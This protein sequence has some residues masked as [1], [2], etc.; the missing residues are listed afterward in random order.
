[1]SASSVDTVKAKSPRQTEVVKPVHNKAMTPAPSKAI[2]PKLQKAMV[3]NLTKTMVSS[4]KA[5]VPIS[6]KAMVPNSLEA[7]V[8]TPSKAMVPTSSK[9]TMPTVDPTTSN[10]CPFSFD[11]LET[12]TKTNFSLYEQTIASL[13]TQLQHAQSNWRD[14]VNRADLANEQTVL[15][16]KMLHK[17][18]QDIALLRIENDKLKRDLETERSDRKAETASASEY[19]KVRTDN[20]SL[21]SEVAKLKHEMNDLVQQR[22]K[23][24][25]R[26]RR[27]EESNSECALI[28]QH[29]ANLNRLTVDIDIKRVEAIKMIQKLDE[30]KYKDLQACLKDLLKLAN[31]NDKVLYFQ[32]SIFNVHKGLENRLSYVYYPTGSGDGERIPDWEKRYARLP[33][34]IEEKDPKQN[35]KKKK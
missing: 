11:G 5:M 21:S 23:Q 13:K 20:I 34:P 16:Q 28:K 19:V 1:M 33:W 31:A 8:P 10:D 6:S 25:Q 17:K 32:G 18:D 2:V 24:T 35:L 22:N 12:V 27:A 14:A 9:A 3:P 4:P 7:R 29:C 30:P 26:A 15:T